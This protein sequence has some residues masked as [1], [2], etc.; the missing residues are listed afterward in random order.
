MF[1]LFVYTMNRFVLL[2]E[3][4]RNHPVTSKWMTDI[5]GSRSEEHSSFKFTGSGTLFDA[6]LSFAACAF[7]GWWTE[8]TLPLLLSC[9]I[10]IYRE[11]D[12]SALYLSYFKEICHCF[13][14]S[15]LFFIL[16]QLFTDAASGEISRELADEMVAMDALVIE[17]QG[18]SNEF[19][20]QY[21]PSWEHFLEKELSPSEFLS[22]SHT[23]VSETQD[24]DFLK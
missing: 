17:L 3:K 15:P 9:G 13:D 10:I 6:W 11:F 8:Q 1:V 23:Y 12:F 21:W 14:S 18:L 16:Q 7:P 5:Q 24:T 20:N 4:S 2:N 22:F 19:R